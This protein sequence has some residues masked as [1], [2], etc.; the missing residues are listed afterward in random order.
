MRRF[1]ARISNRFVGSFIGAKIDKFRRTV[2]LWQSMQPE[3]DHR[4]SCL[5]RNSKYSIINVT[6]SMVQQHRL[7]SSSNAVTKFN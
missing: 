3:I 6:V 1:H 7:I 2:K 4:R 5:A